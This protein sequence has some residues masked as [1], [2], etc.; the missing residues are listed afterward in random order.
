M[1]RKVQFTA[2]I[3][4]IAMKEIETLAKTNKPRVRSGYVVQVQHDAM[5][6]ATN[7]K[8]PGFILNIVQ[9]GKRVIVAQIEKCRVFSG[10][11]IEMPPQV[12]EMREALKG[13]FVPVI[14]GQDSTIRPKEVIKIIQEI[15]PAKNTK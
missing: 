10:F 1:L 3:P 9:D 11:K 6:I 13:K 4:D 15:F 7:G 12:H 14:S 2:R 5:S 8:N